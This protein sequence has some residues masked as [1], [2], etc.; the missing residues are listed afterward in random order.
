MA[1][2]RNIKPSIMDN[3]QLAE[4]DPLTRLLFI[5]LWMLADREGRLEDRP[6]RIAAQALPYDRSADVDAMLLELANSGFIVRYVADGQALIQ[7]VAFSKHQ[8]PHVR[9]AASELP[10]QVQSTAKAVTEH[11]Q[12]DADTSPRSPDRGFLIP[13]TGSLIEESAADA[14]SHADD[15]PPGSSVPTMAGAVCI[16]LRARGIPAVNPAHPDLLALL[17]GGAEIGSFVAAADKA[18]NAGK[19]SF[20]YVLAVVKGQIADSQRLAANARASPAGQTRKDRQL[21]TAAGLTG[22]VRR[23]QPHPV[24]TIDVVS[25]IIPS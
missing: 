4:L 11:D 5:Y 7:I 20:A 9:E 14:A 24:E 1:R 13:D 16:T 12:G 15:V 21:E 8:T 10:A 3:D 25:R 23:Q 6:K 2:S 22:A 19:G 17:E 18:V